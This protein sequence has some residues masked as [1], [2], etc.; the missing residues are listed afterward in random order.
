M[1]EGLL[2]MSS[3]ERERIL[4]VSRIAEQALGRGLAADRLG[5]CIR[6]VERAHFN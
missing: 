2:G 5:D 4:V 3:S 6:Q 1:V